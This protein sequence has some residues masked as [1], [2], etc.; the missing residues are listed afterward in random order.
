M[1]LPLRTFIGQ[2]RRV[3]GREQFGVMSDAELLRRY[4]GERDEAAFEVLV[5]RHGAMVLGVCRR[6]LGHEQDAE[7]A[8]QASFLALARAA[9]TVSRRESVGGWLYR[10]AS[11]IARR[12][13][14]RAVR[15]ARVA[16]EPREEP[17]TS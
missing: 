13:Q 11:R 16:R 8:F 2:M 6:L 7:D 1:N 9:A 4:A 15:R 14:V 3:T 10:V 17:L 5:W 12:A